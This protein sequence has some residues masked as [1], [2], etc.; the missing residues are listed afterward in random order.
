MPLSRLANHKIRP[1]HCDRQALIY[2]RQSTLLQVRANTG[3]TARQYDLVPRALELGWP[4]ERIRV[5]D[6]DQGQS[7]ASAA[8]R[9]GFQ[10]LVAEVGLKHAG[11]VFCLEASRLARSCSDWYH[12]LEICALTDTLVVDEEG[13]YDPGQ[14]NDRLLLGFKGTMSEAELHWLRQRLWGGKLAKAELGQLRFRLP[15][16]L[17]YDPTGR[18]VLDPDQ[19][20]SEA[21]RLVFALFAQ[22]GSALAVVTH[23][24]QH[25]V[26]FPTRLWGGGHDGELV[27]GRL[28]S[29]RVLSILHNPFYAGAYVY[30]RTV[31]RTQVLPGEAPRIKGRT[32]QL[33]RDDWP[34]VLLDAHP[35]YITW[36]QFRHHQQQLDDNRTWR[37]ED[38]RGAVREGAAMLQGL[39]LCGRCGR[40]ISVRYLQD[41]LTP[42]YECNQAHTQHAAP[43]CQTMRGDTIDAAVT[44]RFLEAIQPAQLEVSLAALDQ[45]EARA[46][47]LEHQW[48]LRRERAQYEIDLARRRYGAVEPENRLVA[49][50]LEREWNAK[51]AHLEQLERE[52][53]AWS[54]RAIRPVSPEERQR[55]LALA[56]DVPAVWY[57]PTT[58]NTERKQLLRCLVRD[59]TLTRRDKTITIALRWQTGAL[60]T[61]DIPRLR[62]SW[63]VRQ[64]DPHAVARIREL[65]PQQTDQ[66]IA[67][68]LNAEGLQAGLGGLFTP[69]KVGWIRW[70]YA[71]ATGCP[72]RPK[73]CPTGQRGD[74][75]YS[76]QKA[77]EVLNVHVSTISEWCKQGRL[78]GLRATP[79]GPRW[80]TL[81]PEIITALRP[82]TRRRHCRRGTVS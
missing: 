46:R 37:P 20:V 8:A 25:H 16:G 48:Q 14:Y 60:T 62:R 7:G 68:C 61:F 29:G 15:V 65:A 24:A 58:T 55:I 19:E 63:E 33:K 3:S 78:D 52:Y 76:A 2:V 73:A 66:Q 74:G 32:R 56:Q 70:A 71:I 44:Q 40:R 80:I 82:P 6:Q 64:T 31:T 34:I 5:I 57:A 13:V 30:G 26:R 43:T 11:A 35:G 72:E 38:R 81:T 69:S 75:R 17:V 53:T 18:V 59:V 22:H 36:E 47:Q 50:A 42:L 12:L 49:R 79:M 77:A 54:T 41:G 39:V 27:W 28:T 10:W 23:F 4:R 67:A 1:D 21:V 9:D 45:I 51:L